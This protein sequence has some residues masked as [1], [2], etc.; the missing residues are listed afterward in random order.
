MDA[1]NTLHLVENSAEVQVLTSIET[2]EA[3]IQTTDEASEKSQMVKE[4]SKVE[5]TNLQENCGQE[6]ETLEEAIEKLGN[7]E[8]DGVDNNGD[9]F[10]DEIYDQLQYLNMGKK[11]NY[12]IFDAHF[13]EYD[14]LNNI[15]FSVDDVPVLVELIPT[16]LHVL[17]IEDNDGECQNMKERRG[18]EFETLD[19]PSEMVEEDGLTDNIYDELEDLNGDCRPNYAISSYAYFDECELSINV[20]IYYDVNDLVQLI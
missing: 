6:F 16:E 12:G 8:L 4:H 1:T 7:A 3:N 11:S 2:V 20:P 15:P 18:Q 17:T 5:G 10:K 9:D 13:I 19:E 14:P